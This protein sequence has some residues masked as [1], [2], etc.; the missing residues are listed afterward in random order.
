MF[1]F[2]DVKRITVR[3]QIKRTEFTSQNNNM[4][5]RS[6]SDQSLASPSLSYNKK[7]YTKKPS[8]YDRWTAICFVIGLL[9]ILNAIWMLI[10]P[11]H[12]YYNLPANVPESG[13]LNV[14]FVR[15]LGCIFLLLGC[16][17]L[18][19]G[20]GLVQFRLPLFTMNTLFNVLHMIVHIH[21]IVSG[22]LRI[23]IFWID[24]P[25]IYFPTI[26]TCLLNIN[27]IKQH[28]N[29]SNAKFLQVQPS[30]GLN[31]PDIL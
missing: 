3:R 4:Q 23:G 8:A 17:L 27:L 25:F 2:V 12:W 29:S 20:F 11:Q 19:G 7:V 9:N 18:V 26:I 16:G 14:H 22:R 6:W 28:M 5:R 30:S 15:D 13:P 21:E 24:L 10:A 31:R 1:L